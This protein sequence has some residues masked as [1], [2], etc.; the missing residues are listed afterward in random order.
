[1]ELIEKELVSINFIVAQF[2]DE[3]EALYEKI[4]VT[5]TEKLKKIIDELAPNFSLTSITTVRKIKHYTFSPRVKDAE[6]LKEKLI[7][8]NLFNDFIDILPNGFIPTDGDLIKR[9]KDKLI[10]SDDLIGIKILTDLNTDCKKMF[11]LINSSEFI[12][13]AKAQD[14][15]LN[16]E[17]LK[18]QPQPMRNGLDI[19]K[20]RGKY[21]KFNFELQIKSKIISAWGDMEHSIFYKDYAISPVRDS[22]QKSMNHVGKLLF[23]IDDFVE[24][25]RSANKDYS[26]NA[27]AL[28][29]LQWF[30]S[31]YNERI[32]AKLD[33]VG[34]RMDGISE[35]LYSSYKTLGSKE[36]FSEKE[37]KFSHFEFEITD[38]LLR[39]YVTRRN[40]IYDL[41]ILEGIV[42]GW[43]LDDD[44]VIT[45]DNI[46]EILNKYITIL[47]K[48]AASFLC[49]RHQ[50]FDEQE[51]QDI[52]KLYY[53][54]GFEYEC[55]E[56][57][58]LSLK[59]LNDFLITSFYI[60]DLTESQMNPEIVEIIKKVIFVT[61]NKGKNAECINKLIN[62]ITP[63]IDKEE[64]KI[65]FIQFF[66]RIESNNQKNKIELTN[67][68]KN[69][70]DLL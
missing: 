45:Q 48:A 54:I 21:D 30:D 28:M 64:F 63:K 33:N 38:P 16:Q 15:N 7:R 46:E 10:E 69:I 50:A 13:K 26:Q 9:V 61:L 53:E 52:V 67:I 40:K 18:K 43:L 19:Y 39:K 12:T 66:D 58:L 59:Q 11:E 6:S 14:I 29:F 1:M 37:L 5:I 31:K 56:R 57:F 68:S 70:I 3:R 44:I 65:K 24:S 23:Q 51:M 60:D 36:S 25:I 22:A 35:L 42:I 4:T 20:I 17:D 55:S 32:R 41:K 8:N 49:E 62:E 47:V 27:F 34:F 2:T